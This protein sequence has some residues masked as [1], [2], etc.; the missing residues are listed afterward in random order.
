MGPVACVLILHHGEPS[1][2]GIERFKL[3]DAAQARLLLDPAR[4]TWTKT[5]VEGTHLLWHAGP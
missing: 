2:S 4:P 1:S 3:R 5:V